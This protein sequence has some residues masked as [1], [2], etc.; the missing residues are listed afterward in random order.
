MAVFPG[1]GQAQCEKIYPDD[2]RKEEGVKSLL[3]NSFSVVLPYYNEVGYLGKALATWLAQVRKPD[4]LI[5]VDNG[6][7]DGSTEEAR[8]V[9]GGSQVKGI[10]VVF[11]HEG[12]PGKIHALAT[13]CRAVTGEFTVLADADTFYPPHYLE[14][15][16]RLFA[17]SDGRI[18]ALMALPEFDRPLSMGSRVRRRYFI[19]LNKLFRKHAFTGG[20]GQVFRT[21]ALVAA[22][23]FSARLWPHVLLDHEIMY[24]VFKKGLSRYDMDL[25]CQSSLRRTSRRRV[26]WNLWERLLYQFTPHCCQ[27]WFFYKFLGPRFEKKGLNHIRL[28]EQPWN[29]EKRDK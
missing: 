18:V 22:G 13:G 23:G 7:T 6:S 15:C 17:G 4:Q 9:I 5:L 11:L 20:Y 24:R 10:D 19:I 8:E 3:K 21:E 1:R 14:L 25:W 29:I 26:R 16:E 2:R 28:R 27:G 12:E